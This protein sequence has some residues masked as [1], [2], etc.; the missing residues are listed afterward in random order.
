MKR[1]LKQILFAITPAIIAVTDAAIII[2]S[3]PS[4]LPTN[5]KR[6]KKNNSNK[7]A[8]KRNSAGH[9]TA[10]NAIKK[11]KKKAKVRILAKAAICKEVI[12][13]VNDDSIEGGFL[14]PYNYFNL[15]RLG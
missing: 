6:K 1:I 7:R 2:F 10:I 4:Q 12:I 8:K 14:G 5:R 13:G 15:S 9:F 11:E 3:I